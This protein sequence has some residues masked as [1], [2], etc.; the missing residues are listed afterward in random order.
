MIRA[1]V[2]GA[3]AC[4]PSNIVTNEDLAKKMDTSDEWIQGRTGI[5]QRHIALPGEKTSDLALGAARAALTDAGID[6]DEL[7]LIIVA[8]TTPDR[9]VPSVATMVQARL[10]MS[11]GA[12][13]DDLDGDGAVDAVILNSRREPTILRKGSNSTSCPNGSASFPQLNWRD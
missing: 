7:D 10:G 2:I 13:F 9:T 6:A 8:T 5:Q 4:L 1:R 12:A 11:R 3:G